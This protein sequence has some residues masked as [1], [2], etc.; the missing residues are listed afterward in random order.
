MKNC[1]M[2]MSATLLVAAGYAGLAAAHA[3]SGT[4]GRAASA[5]AA[6]DVY[7]VTCSNNGSGAPAKLFL[8]VKDLPLVLAPVI[9]IQAT[10]STVASTQSVDTK[11]GDA[12]YSKGVFLSAGAGVYSLKVNKF[13]S[14][15]KG[16]ET[17]TAQFH[18]LTAAG[19][20]T[21][22]TWVMTQNQ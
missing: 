6:T 19:V 10:K 9:G 5:A 4:L 22:T 14:T 13:A 20:H 16:A 11:D 7:K 12:V 3:L 1:K 2:I 15:V 18:C 17:Y 21:G 8:Q